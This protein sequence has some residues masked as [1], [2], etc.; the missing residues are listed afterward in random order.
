MRSM[1][2]T[3]ADFA[4][5]WKQESEL[6]LKILRALTDASL[7]QRCTGTRTL[8]C[9]AWHVTVTLG[10]ML[11]HGGLPVAGAVDDKA[12]APSTAAAIVDAYETGAR[13]VAEAVAANWTDA[14][15]GE[16]IPMYGEQWKRS[17]VLGALIAHQT[18]HRGQ[19]TILMRQAGLTVPG[20]YGPAREEWAAYGMPAPE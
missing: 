9:L 17:F 4:A 18:H 19:M 15:L 16:E 11:G 5:T 2:R 13:L 8:G 14:Q 7:E 12:P 1:F 6:T 10:E 20:V 3:I